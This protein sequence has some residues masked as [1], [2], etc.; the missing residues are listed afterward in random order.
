MQGSSQNL[1][2]SQKATPSTQ[3]QPTVPGLAGLA[4]AVFPQAQAPAVSTPRTNMQ[5]AEAP[6]EPL[7]AQVKYI[8]HAPHAPGAAPHTPRAD[9]PSQYQ[10]PTMTMPA[11]QPAVCTGATSPAHA[12]QPEQRAPRRSTYAAVSPQSPA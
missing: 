7:Q 11:T 8:A 5:V 4:R 3:A 1:L 6:K 2:G 9:R 12:P 10:Q